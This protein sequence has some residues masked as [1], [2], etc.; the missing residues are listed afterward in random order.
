MSITFFARAFES[1]VMKRMALAFCFLLVFQNVSIGQSRSVEASISPELCEDMVR[2]KMLVENKPVSCRRLALVKFSYFG[3]DHKI[4]NDGEIVVL[5]AVAERVRKIFD[6]LFDRQFPLA[7]GAPGAAQSRIAEM[8]HANYR[9]L[10]NG[11]HV[12][13][14]PEPDMVRWPT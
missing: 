14:W 8:A 1:K 6:T 2:H 7:P 12:A 3:F 5:D 10:W 11:R 9:L 4:H 13:S